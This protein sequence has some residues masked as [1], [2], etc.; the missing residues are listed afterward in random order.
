MNLLM[1]T[2]LTGVILLIAYRFYGSLL[3]RLVEIDDR[4]ETPA[5]RYRDDVDYTPIDKYTLLPQHFSAIAAAGPIVGPILAGIMFGW[6][7]ALMWILIGSIFIGGVHD[8]YALVASIRH[9]A[10][11]I[12]QVV[13]EHMSG[14]AY[15]LFLMFVWLSLIYIIVAFTDVTAGSF[16]GKSD[17]DSGV[18]FPAGA[19]ATSSLLYLLL[20]MAMGV[21]LRYKIL[22]VNQATLVFLPLIGVAIW[23]GQY[24]PLDLGAMLSYTPFQTQRTWA[25]LL[26]TYCLVASLLPLWL[27]LQP[28]GYLG[29]YFLYIALAGVLLASFLA[30]RRLPIQW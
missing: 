19:V 27:L 12:A 25:L 5:Q 8:L 13:K 20:P 14:R 7:P 10:S 30:T 3:V 18:A 2:L 1:L 23:C 28:R 6:L 29:G 22:T 17:P 15:I 16:I 4:N 21:L 26:L 24:I 9:R 11:S